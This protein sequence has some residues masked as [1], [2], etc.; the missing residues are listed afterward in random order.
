MPN[1]GSYNEFLAREGLQSRPE[2]I[3]AHSVALDGFKQELARRRGISD[4][5]DLHTMPLVPLDKL[6][7]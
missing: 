4:V 7:D 3:E 6:L 5:H 1:P 2:A